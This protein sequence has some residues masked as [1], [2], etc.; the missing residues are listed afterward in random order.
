MIN[1]VHDLEIRAMSTLIRCHPRSAP[2][3]LSEGIGR[4]RHC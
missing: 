1:V 3:S 2:F 4:R